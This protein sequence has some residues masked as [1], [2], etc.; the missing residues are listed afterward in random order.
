MLYN[1]D[2]AEQKRVLGV[3]LKGLNLGQGHAK[4]LGYAGKL[5]GDRAMQQRAWQRFFAGAAGQLPRDFTSRRVQEPDVLHAV[6]EAPNLSTNGVAQWALA[7]LC[8]LSVAPD[9]LPQ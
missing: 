7:L 5:L 6:D 8:L 3:A 1:A 9:A 2:A 4:L